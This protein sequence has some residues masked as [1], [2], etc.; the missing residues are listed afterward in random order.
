MKR[1]KTNKSQ[2]TDSSNVITNNIVASLNN[3]GKLVHIL[4]KIRDTEIVMGEAY[5]YFKVY[6]FENL[7]IDD[8]NE[9]FVSISSLPCDTSYHFLG[10][11]EYL[12]NK[13]MCFVF[14]KVENN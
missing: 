9:L 12:D 8:R 3:W 5:I 14:K 13:E 7:S 6:Y 11:T 1:R 4:K 10:I 2:F